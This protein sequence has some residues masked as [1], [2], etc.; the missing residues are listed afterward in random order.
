MNETVFVMIR[1]SALIKY[2]TSISYQTNSSVTLVLIPIPNQILINLD[3]F[4][5]NRWK[6]SN[7]SI[8]SLRQKKRNQRK[9][10]N[11]YSLLEA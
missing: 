1:D 2:S 10:R 8:L 6:I 3:L 4:V 7:V 9:K 5:E 11:E